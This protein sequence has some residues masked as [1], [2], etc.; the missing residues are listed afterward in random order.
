LIARTFNGQLVE[1]MT[2]NRKFSVLLG[3]ILL[4]VLVPAQTW[5]VGPKIHSGV[6]WL[7]SANLDRVLE[8]QE[9]ARPGL[10][11]EQNSVPG[12]V[13]G[14]GGTFLYSYNQSWGILAEVTLSR[15]VSHMRGTYNLSS[16]VEGTGTQQEEKSDITITSDAINL[17][18]L[19][20]YTF[21]EGRG[22]YLL[23]GAQISFTASPDI[24][25]SEDQSSATF[26]NHT[27]N[28]SSALHTSARATAN[29]SKDS[30]LSLVGG[31]GYPVHFRRHTLLIDV[32][33]ATVLEGTPMYT[34]DDQ[35]QQNT[36]ENGK[37]YSRRGK[38]DYESYDPGRFIDDFR[39]S[40]VEVSVS[41]LLFQAAAATCFQAT[42]RCW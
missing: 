36:M 38:V 9:S 13:L 7:T 25:T 41:Y 17:P 5:N 29:V 8:A 14:L 30:R 16:V 20:K 42:K 31:I 22:P 1:Q 33:Y 6:S 40:S 37:V 12:L 3:M 34:L 24:E 26:S 18:I 2:H 27:V 15:S 4:P 39:L 32:R 19:F 28:Q 11:L 21:R 23:A 10:T 35:F